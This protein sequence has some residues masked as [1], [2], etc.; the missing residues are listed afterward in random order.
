MSKF[1]AIILAAGHG[2][3]MNS[4]VAK[5][6]MLLAERPLLYYSLKAFQ[7]SDVD[8][9][10]LVVGSSEEKYVLDNV[11]VPYSFTKVKRLVVGG[12]ERYHSVYEGLKAVRSSDYVLI[13]D[14]ARPFVTKSMICS[15]MEEV[16]DCDACIVGVPSKD[17]V[18]I[19]NEQGYVV[20]T[21]NRN[22][23]RN[24][25]TPQAFSYQLINGAY[26]KL[27]SSESYDVT[28]DAMIVELMTK[29]PIRL[30][31]GSYDNIKITTP[32]DILIAEGIAKRVGLDENG[33]IFSY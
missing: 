30:L 29:H 15:I 2:K 12:K 9:I 25:Q 1:T 17:T 8:E 20:D 27:M 4:S 23:V 28:D 32:E 19:V 6:Y 7:E 22:Y 3:R 13:H 11:I 14:G 5:Q 16:K 24:V 26:E 10:V 33:V 31:L 18:K 21:P